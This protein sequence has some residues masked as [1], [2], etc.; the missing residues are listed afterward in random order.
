VPLSTFYTLPEEND[1]VSLQIY[2]HVKEDTLALFGF[3]TKLEKDLFLLLISIP[4][5]GPK[6]SIN[7]LSGMGPQDLLEAMASGNAL[8][9]QA[10]PGVGK[11]TAERISVELRDRAAKILGHQG[12]FELSVPEEKD[13]DVLE[14]AVSALVNLGYTANSAKKAIEEARSTIKE[15]TLEGLIRGALKILAR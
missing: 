14:D 13:K 10:I 1:A 8:R 6:L 3:N 4:G 11:K 15:F 9:L 2:T 7:I 12:V 5:I